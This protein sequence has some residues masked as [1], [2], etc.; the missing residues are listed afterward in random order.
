[1]DEIEFKLMYNDATTEASQGDAR[2]GML[3]ILQ[4]IADLNARLIEMQVDED[5]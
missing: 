2:K 5:E 3:L 1:M 4:L